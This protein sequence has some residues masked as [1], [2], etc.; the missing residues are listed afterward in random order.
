[1][2]GFAAGPLAYTNFYPLLTVKGL[3]NKVY[4]IGLFLPFTLIGLTTIALETGLT[5]F[6]YTGTTFLIAYVFFYTKLVFLEPAAAY[7]GWFNL[8][9][10]T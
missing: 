2:P 8:L 9:A 3:A 5:I 7:F 1:M 10:D 6:F 4:E